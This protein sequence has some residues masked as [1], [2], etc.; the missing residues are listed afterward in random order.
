[1]LERTRVQKGHNIGDCYHQQ[2]P[3]MFS[4]TPDP[5]NKM[6]IHIYLYLEPQKPA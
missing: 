3:K 4:V 2:S 5:P 6:P 1:M